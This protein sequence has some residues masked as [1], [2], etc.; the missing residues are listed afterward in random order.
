MFLLE[1]PT[2][3]SFCFQDANT[4]SKKKNKYKQ[5]KHPKLMQQKSEETSMD[6]EEHNVKGMDIVANKVGG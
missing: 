2:P 1:I 5:E 6:K 3:N 4:G